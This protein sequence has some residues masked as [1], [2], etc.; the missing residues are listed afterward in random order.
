VLR[1]VRADS[2]TD[3]WA[4]GAYNNGTVD[5]TLILHW[6]GSHWR[7]W[8]SPNVR[9][10]SNDLN[11]IG[12]TSSANAYAVGITFGGTGSTALILHWGGS[13]WRVMPSPDVGTSGNDLNAVFALSPASVWAAGEYNNSG[14]D[15]T[16]IDYCG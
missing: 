1:G 6:G 10:R 3:A 5:K 9:N 14:P 4:V 12:G 11:A 8:P 2:T 16:L 13:H 7:V 15:Q